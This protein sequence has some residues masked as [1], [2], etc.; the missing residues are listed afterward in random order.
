M[1]QSLVVVPILFMLLTACA[2]R[3]PSPHVK[4]YYQIGEQ[5]ER[6]LEELSREMTK[7]EALSIVGRE[8]FEVTTGTI[9]WNRTTLHQPF[10]VE[11]QKENGREVLVHYYWTR[12]GPEDGFLTPVVFV[13]G[14]VK[15]VGWD[16]KYV[17]DQETKESEISREIVE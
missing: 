8:N 3:T 9:F 12:S 15:T 6:R 7:E 5:N 10:W 1:R 14:V 4:R 17:P 16:N 2:T 13:D 11:R